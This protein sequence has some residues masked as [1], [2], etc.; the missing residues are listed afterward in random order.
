VIPRSVNAR[1]LKARLDAAKMLEVVM[2]RIV[3]E[4]SYNM[5][6]YCRL[7]TA[8]STQEGPS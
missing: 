8:E 1:S 4:H 5:R 7:S 3:I 2:T 6:L